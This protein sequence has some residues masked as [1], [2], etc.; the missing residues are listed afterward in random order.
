MRLSLLEVSSRPAPV[1]MFRRDASAISVASSHG[2]FGYQDI[3]SLAHTQV[4]ARLQEGR[5]CVLVVRVA[6]VEHD[7]HALS[8]DASFVAVRVVGTL[9]TSFL[10]RSNKQ[11]LLRSAQIRTTTNQN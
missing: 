3:S 6:H 4:T 11:R 1:V 8:V 7:K 5:L 10:L 9:S 2:F